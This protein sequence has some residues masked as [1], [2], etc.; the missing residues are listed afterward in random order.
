[1]VSM[2]EI[3][4]KCGVSVA[5]VSKAL[6]DHVD[7]SLATKEMVKSTAR[8]MGYFPNSSARALKTNRTYNLGVLFMDE[9]RNGLT[10]DYFAHILNSFKETAEAK[11]YDITFI[12]SNKLSQK[13][14]YLEHSR[15]RGVDGVVI[16]CVDFHEPEVLELV[17]SDLAVVTIDHT[18][19]NRPSVTSDNIRGMRELIGYVHS[20]GHRKIAYINGGDEST[21]T[22][23]RIG[24]FYRTLAELKIPFIDAYMRKGQYRDVKSSH[25]ETLKLLDLPNPPTCILY[26]D[27]LSAIGGIN[28]IKERGMRIPGDISIA[29]YDGIPIAKVLE[30]R[31]TTVEQDTETIGRRAAEK[32]ISM[33]ENPKTTLIERLIVEG[34]LLTGDTVADISRE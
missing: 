16:A 22:R 3:A 8:E 23:N 30:P 9:A 31:F 15:Y 28:A 24:C 14:T 19:D 27:D 1:M 34:K 29:G 20:M 32:L 11:G 12:N 4:A 33:V 17:N 21:V 26:P 5:T 2:K 7:I 13:M 6:N 10:H 18:F 25:D